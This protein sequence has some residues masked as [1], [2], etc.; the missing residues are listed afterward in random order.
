MITSKLIDDIFKAI[1]GRFTVDEIERLLV[2]D[3]T[4]LIQLITEHTMDEFSATLIPQIESIVIAE[5]TPAI[6]TELLPD[7]AVTS[8]WSFSISE[9]FTAQY[10]REFV[11]NDIRE[12][13]DT[14][15]A[16]VR[17]TIERGQ[18]Q[19]RNPRNIAVDFRDN[20]GLTSRME[21]AVANYRAGLESL[22][23]EV[24]NR[25]LRDKRFDST[26]RNAIGSGK[27]LTEQQID[28]MVQRYRERAI[29]SRSETIAR[30]EQLTAVTVG[31][32]QSLLQ[33]RDQGKLSPRLRRFWEPTHDGRT[34][35][36][37]FNIPTLN[38]EGVTI[39]EQYLTQPPGRT[40]YVSAPRDPMVSAANR[41]N[42][43][44]RERYE[45]I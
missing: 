37:H 1:R 8:P 15:V 41:V 44:C 28:K 3:P 4:G 42:C 7:G 22:S 10:I 38:P 35:H 26:I 19:G 30:T 23:P 20:I 2:T 39:D 34:R 12:I 6:V 29:K 18:Q 36:Y 9:P 32:R 33:A 24:L 16:A 21:Q 13:T 27:E 17:Q 11:G 45:L 43:R 25:V 14:T 31:Q 5:G 40:E